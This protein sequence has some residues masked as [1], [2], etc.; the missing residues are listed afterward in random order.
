MESSAVNLDLRELLGSDHPALRGVDVPPLVLDHQPDEDGNDLETTYMSMRR[1]A[2][3]GAISYHKEE[4][5]AVLI[6]GLGECP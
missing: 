6:R 3:R 5:L 4:A 1:T 2:R